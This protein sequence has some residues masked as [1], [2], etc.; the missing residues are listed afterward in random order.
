MAET[1]S[2]KPPLLRPWAWD[3]RTLLASVIGAGLFGLAA[4][5][6]IAFTRGDDRIAAVW[7]PNALAV[8]FLLRAKLNGE[9]TFLSSL[10]IANFIANTWIGDTPFRAMALATANSVEMFAAI[11]LL[12]YFGTRRPDM[13]DIRQLMI[14][15]ALAGISA[16]VI[17]ASFAFA[18]LSFEEQ[19]STIVWFEWMVT[20]GLS[21]I[22]LVPAI[23]IFADAMARKRP[24]SRQEKLDWALLTIPGTLLTIYVFSQAQ[25][26]LLFLVAPVVVSHAFRLGS[27]GTAFSMVKVAVISTTFTWLGQGPIHLI[28]GGLTAQLMTL[29]AFLATAFL[30]GLP[31]AAVLHGRDA[32]LREIASSREELDT[33]AH[34]ITDAVMRFDQQGVCTYASP[35][36]HEV[37]GRP[38]AFYLGRPASQETHP[39]AKED[40]AAA[41]RRLLTGES[42]KERLTYRRLED[43][44]QGEPVYIEADCAVTFDR[45]TG[46]HSGIIVSARDVTERV[47]LERDLVN[48]RRHAEQAAR[49]KS[50]FLANMSHEIRTPMNGVLGFAELLLQGD[51]ADEQR[52]QA[53]MIHD[54]GRSMMLLLNDILDLSKIEAGQVVI[55]H[56]PVDIHHL[57][58]SCTSLH[59]AYAQRKGLQLVFR[60]SD[61]LHRHILTDQLRLKQIV[62]NLI[63]N[64]VKF[65]ERGTIEVSTAVCNDKLAIKV[66]DTGI[67]IPQDR[68]D[69]IFKPF[70]QADSTTSRRFGGTGLGLSISRNLAE[71][72]GGSLSCISTPGKGSQFTLAIPLELAEAAATPVNGPGQSGN[73]EEAL[74][75]SRVLLAEDHD[76]NRI[77][78]TTMLERCGQEVAVA[79]DGHEAVTMIREAYE[80]HNPYDLVLM[81]IQMP[82]CD[83]YTAARRVRAMGIASRNLPIIALTANAFPEDIAAARDAGMQGHLAKP[84]VFAELGAVLRRW[85]PTKILDHDH[86]GHRL[87]HP[88]TGRSNTAQAGVAAPDIAS[89]SDI[90]D[91][92]D[93]RRQEA[94]TAVEQALERE[95]LAGTEGLELAR[96]VHKLAGTAGVFGEAELGA[97]TSALERALKSEQPRDVTR[98]LATE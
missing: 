87:E 29:Q 84:L 83:G 72:L 88:D 10:W 4:Y 24:A 47:R 48:A 55:N 42:R 16:P 1:H 64:A 69:D 52:R 20:D 89:S 96:L 7:I 54:S 93:E 79:R 80:A 61:I 30:I 6:S 28:D 66:S 65:T 35:S 51:L 98:K 62:L 17:S 45:E 37:L 38:R 15:V 70:Q 12:R 77:L 23:L 46:E 36:V 18:A 78:A 59:A 39:D 63:G 58:R 33:L 75:P 5:L 73:A 85:L 11:L 57:L 71:L 50:E 68:H 31:V 60:E 21:M 43:D 26:P 82:G 74:R 2:N 41:E 56:E 67:G 22:I 44:D 9:A 86:T 27:L 76:I 95:R 32:M 34:S 90:R 91:R 3:T 25:Y 14:F 97:K 53:E 40:I 8:A 94:I 13:R 92:W 19:T 81:D 49:A